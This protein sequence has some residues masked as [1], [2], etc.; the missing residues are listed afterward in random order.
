[1]SD[2]TSDVEDLER[3]FVDATAEPIKISYAAIKQIT[4]NFAQ[5]IGDG[6][7]GVVYL[8]GLQ[9]GMVAVK[10]LDILKD[11]SDKL[12][13]DEVSCLKRVN[14]KNIARFLGY[15]ADAQGEVMEVE[16]KL[17]IVEVHQRLLCFEYVPNGSLHHYLKEK[18]H[19]YEWN[20]RYQII[21]GICQGLH[22]LHKKCIYHLDLKPAN[23]LLGAHMEPKITDF[24]VSRCIDEEQSMMVT[25]N[26][27]GTR[28]YVA[29][30][31]IEK[32][33]ISFKSDIFSLGVT[34]INI[35][36]GRNGGIIE[37]WQETIDVDC[38]Q[39]KRCI[40]LAQ[41]CVDSDPHNRPTMTEIIHKQNETETMFQK[42]PPIIRE[43]RNDPE[44]SLY[45]DVQRFQALSI[46][47]LRE[48][49]RLDDIFVE[50]NV[51]ECILEGSKKPSNLSYRLLQFITEN[52]SDERKIGTNRYPEIYKGIL[53]SVTV[54]RLISRDHHVDDHVF[55]Q[56]VKG[57]TMAQHQNIV[58][59]LGYCSY[60][61]E[62][63]S[64]KDGISVMAGKCE[65]L[66]C[67]EY[68]SH[69]SL[70]D[71]LSDASCGLE[72]RVR[73]ELIMGICEGLR[74]L[75]GKH[76]LHL[77]LKPSN[78]LLDDNMVPKISP[79]FEV[80]LDMQKH[81]VG[82]MEYL[83]PESRCGIISVKSDIYSFG[84]I[85]RE[86]LTGQKGCSPID[87]VL[88]S[89]RNRLPTSSADTL[90]E[91]VRVCAEI[92]IACMVE[93]PAKRPDTQRIIEMLVET[94]RR[95]ELIKKGMSVFT[96]AEAEKAGNVP[97]D[98]GF[99]QKI[100]IKVSM[101]YEKSRS[102][103]MRLAAR[104]EGVISVTITGDGRDRLE[105]A[106]DCV[107]V[108][109]LVSSL[110]RKIGHAEILQ[111]QQAGEARARGNAAVSPA[112][113]RAGGA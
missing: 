3:I 12:F 96:V 102:Q 8:G 10:K 14:H 69:G 76:F 74:Y 59:F 79:P 32:K 87:N 86:I 82:S 5:V 40:E 112:R 67:F 48:N 77:D 106:G 28:G 31:F 29:P 27:F 9:N 18:T 78:I 63:P 80:L 36:T 54:Q 65:R 15:C 60:N 108:V 58:R 111:V 64:E 88:E 47:T 73:Y 16:G 99:M 113:A 95:D 38:P 49:S 83:A 25:E 104:A 41:I 20:V 91:Q 71:Y 92:S 50:L 6:G 42:D 57:K 19:G 23:V 30:E 75:H 26:F 22:Y 70:D 51:L 37:N 4:K 90:L 84:V 89:W 17:R 2:Q 103:A 21:N 66:L 13:L 97:G 110:R 55:H 45:Q 1:M 35:L 81:L 100:V 53:R 101:P 52:F 61:E 93:D 46:Q 7:F 94:G 39:M 109:G 44:S 34:M 33:Q 107:D 43:P 24:G 11:F 72:W 56:D 85:I 68:L 98:A 62:R 105:V